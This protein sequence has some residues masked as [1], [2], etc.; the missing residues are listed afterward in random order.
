MITC[1][2][3]G[4]SNIDFAKTCIKCGTLLQTNSPK[5]SKISQPTSGKNPSTSSQSSNYGRNQPQTSQRGQQS[6]NPTSYSSS[7]LNIGSF[8]ISEIISTMTQG[9][10]FGSSGSLLVLI[11]FF[12]PWI[13]ASCGGN[14]QVEFTGWELAAGTTI[15]SVFGT[16]PVEGN[17]ILFLILI[18]SLA[19][20]TLAYFAY[21]RGF[22]SPIDGY[23][24]IASGI[25][26]LLILVIQ[27]SGLKDEAAQQNVYVEFRYGLWGTVLGYLAV[28]IGG[29]LNRKE[30]T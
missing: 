16:E 20:L 17:P 23:G 9:Y 12:L 24:L 19:V 15:R 1:S 10:K 29:F 28:I 8:N 13:F 4:S 22:L 7:K 26:S 27:F 2:N 30:S 6:N 11:C 14:Q 3:C 5:R 25:L 18:A 21:K